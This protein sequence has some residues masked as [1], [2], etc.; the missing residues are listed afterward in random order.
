M[1]PKLNFLSC[2]AAFGLF[3]LPWIN[4]QCSNSSVSSSSGILATQTGAQMT[5]GGYTPTKGIEDLEKVS[6]EE[7][8]KSLPGQV[9]ASALG[10]FQSGASSLKDVHPGAS[11]YACSAFILATAAMVFAFL[12]FRDGRSTTLS[13]ALGT[14]ALVALI[15]LKSQGFPIE[16][17]LEVN[18]AAG[19][20]DNPIGIR[21]TTPLN[22]EIA[23]AL[24]SFW[25]A[26]LIALG[27]PAL[28]L[29]NQLLDRMKKTT[30]RAAPATPDGPNLHL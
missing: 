9:F 29:G 24:T 21:I 4:L 20:A 14:A 16:K 11:I 22:P 27:I 28:I 26:E 17:K 5:Y 13:G 10:K 7:L 25:Y 8:N 19:A 23:T 15:L 18:H 2:L 30:G 1:L 12:A 3:F 6:Q